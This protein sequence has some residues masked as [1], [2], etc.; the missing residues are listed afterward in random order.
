MLTSVLR[1]DLLC[2]AG[3]RRACEIRNSA[4]WPCLRHIWQVTRRSSQASMLFARCLKEFKLNG[5]SLLL[6]DDCA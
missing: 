4:Y 1:Q 3:R 6:E 5:P 2:A